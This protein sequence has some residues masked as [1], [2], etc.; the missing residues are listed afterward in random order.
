MSR[1]VGLAFAVMLNSFPR[2]AGWAC[3]LYSRTLAARPC[4]ARPRQYRC[5]DEYRRNREPRRLI[6]LQS[7]RHP[8]FRKLELGTQPPHD[9]GTID[10]EGVRSALFFEHAQTRSA[11]EG[12]AVPTAVPCCNSKPPRMTCR[13]RIIQTGHNNGDLGGRWTLVAGPR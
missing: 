8:A 1:P 12:T 2:Q 13:L 11:S 6:F 4:L 7:G 3:P 9:R 5:R 10:R